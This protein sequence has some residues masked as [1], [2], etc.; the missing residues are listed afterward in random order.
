MFSKRKA[1][2]D[3]AFISYPCFHQRKDFRT[4]KNF[5]ISAVLRIW[6]NESRKWSSIAGS[7]F[8]KLS[9]STQLEGL[10][11]SSGVR[12]EKILVDCDIN[13]RHFII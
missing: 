13:A 8:R 3:L 2:F 12:V 9:S 5:K 6:K 10:V 1:L 11:E 7:D 4:G